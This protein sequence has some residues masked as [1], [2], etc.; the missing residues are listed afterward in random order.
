MH[1]EEPL[2]STSQSMRVGNP[3]PGSAN[4]KRTSAGMLA[5]LLIGVMMFL[6][7]NFV[8]R[9]PGPV[10]NTLGDVEGT[11][12]ISIDGAESYE[13]DSTLDML[14]VYVQGGGNNRVTVPVIL[15]ALVNPTKDIAPEETVI[16]RGV[17]SDQQ[18]EE[19]DLQM[20]SSQDQAIAAALTELGYDF[21]TW[22]DV[23]GFATS[24]NESVLKKGDR[25][26][27]FEGQPIKSLEQLKEDLNQQGDKESTLKVLRE[28]K[29][30]K[31]KEITVKVKT[32][33]G[34]EGQRQLGVLL[35]TS[36]KFPFDVKFGVENIGGPSAGMM[37]ALAIIDRLTEGSLA[38]D[39][40][41]AGTGTID[42]EGN[43]G[44]IGGI[45]Q[46]MVAAQRSGATVFLAP[47]D[48][49]AEVV[50]R[51]PD[52]LDVVKV[53]TLG[54]ARQKLEDI[55]GGADPASMTTCE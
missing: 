42:Q 32:T 14:T 24:T 8:V 12:L 36:H 44:P 3:G 5:L 28:V 49:C 13:S 22:L 30:A 34:E 23:V 1:Q 33:E 7:T 11:K 27:A 21:K 39:H 41:V 46:K 19:N 31:A 9:S 35:S 4:A 47:A 53:S 20:V 6:P 25:L 40:Q 18:S 50:G 51:V 26:L 55:A 37:F 48:N 17:T 54:E 52:G 15:E 38:G 45:A 2:N 10:L 16:P 43:V 29:D